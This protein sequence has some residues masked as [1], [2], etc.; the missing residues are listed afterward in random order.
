MA[1][2][3]GPVT[4]KLPRNGFAKTDLGT[5]DRRG[6]GI[7]MDLQDHSDLPLSGLYQTVEQV[8]V[9]DNRMPHR[10]P[11]MFRNLTRHWLRSLSAVVELRRRFPGIVDN[12]N[13]RLCVRTSPAGSHCRPRPKEATG[14]PDQIIEAV[15]A[16]SIR[17][18]PQGRMCCR[19]NYRCTWELRYKVVSA[20]CRPRGD[21]AC[22]TR[23]GDTWLATTVVP[24]QC[25]TTKCLQL[26]T[27]VIQF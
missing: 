15:M 1:L 3:G 4:F 18:T 24:S 25:M 8:A 23:C 20:S 7:L 13:A 17:R 21:D 9:A 10:I 27:R 16:R 14:M 26:W 6:A 12:E 11:T 5:S 22:V 2:R 19:V